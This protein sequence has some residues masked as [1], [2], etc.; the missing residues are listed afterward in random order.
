MGATF[1]RAH[2]YDPMLFVFFFLLLVTA[3]L[4]AILGPYAYPQKRVAKIAA[5]AAE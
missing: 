1:D 2:S 3:V 5:V 4:L